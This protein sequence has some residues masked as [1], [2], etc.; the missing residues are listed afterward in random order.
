MDRLSP[1]CAASRSNRGPTRGPASACSILHTSELCQESLEPK[2]WAIR[3]TIN[4]QRMFSRAAIRT[5]WAASWVPSGTRSILFFGRH[6]TGPLCY[7][8]QQECND[9][10]VPDKGYHAYPYVS[11]VW[12][13]DL[14]SLLAVKN[15][16]SQ[17]Y[18]PLPYAMWTLTPRFGSDWATIRGAAY[19]PATKRI[20]LAAYSD[21]EGFA[22]PVI[23]VYKLQV[24]TSGTT[25][26]IGAPAAPT[27]L[28]VQ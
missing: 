14:N 2:S 6:G 16:Q 25:T 21:D 9:P 15:G 10:V 8:T 1:D 24:G 12:A 3:S 4:R 18:Q 5:Q 26:T 23:H 7:G 20:F 17:E 28:H 27:N 22:R 13:Y 19:D 11:R